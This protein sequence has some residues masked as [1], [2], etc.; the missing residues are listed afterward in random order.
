MHLSYFIFGE[1]SF[2]LDSFREKVISIEM[3]SYFSRFATLLLQR[4][5]TRKD[6]VFAVVMMHAANI[7]KSVY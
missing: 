6:Q 4:L 7:N 1:G 5:Q 3:K 2:S